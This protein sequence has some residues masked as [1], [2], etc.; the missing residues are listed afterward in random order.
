MIEPSTPAH[1]A[2]CVTSRTSVKRPSSAPSVEPG[3]KPNQPSHRM[4]TPRPNSGM[5]WPGIARGLPSG[6]DLPWREPER[7]RAGGAPGAPD[8]GAG[9]E[10]QERGERAG[11]ADQVDGRRAGEVL[12]AEV[13]LQPAAAEDP[14]R[15][16]RVDQRAEHDRVDDVDAELD[17]LER[18]APHDGERDGAEDELEE[19]LRLDGR[20]GQAHDREGLQRVAVVAQEEPGV[21]DD[22]A[23]AEREGEA[24]RPVTKGGD[25]EV[26][27]DLRHYGSRVL[28]AR[29]ADLQEGESGLHEHDEAGGD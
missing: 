8:Q 1:A 19:P 25:G 15:G 26:G 22:V 3:L 12:H 13:A 7:T 11:R 9:G 24:D 18:R 27:Q 14:A 21:A 23:R 20:V 16:D 6:P 10:Q 29:E 28:A 4:I 5:L 2:S 17:A